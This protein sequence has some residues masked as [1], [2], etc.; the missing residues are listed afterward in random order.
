MEAV[1]ATIRS[2]NAERLH[3]A[4]IIKT[5]NEIDMYMWHGGAHHI[6]YDVHDMV[7]RPK[8][9][10]PNMTFCVDVGIYHEE[11]GIG[12]RLEDVELRDQ[13]NEALKALA[14]DGTIDA[15]AANDDYADIRDFLCVGD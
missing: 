12:F 1:D 6:G 7:E 13:V 9:L 14:A 11:W 8:T 15:I 2:Y 10:A 5:I 3:D 4:G